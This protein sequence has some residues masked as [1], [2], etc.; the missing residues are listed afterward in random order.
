MSYVPL[1][2]ISSY[3]LLQSPIRISELITEA[4]ERGY[5]AL[6]LTDINVMYGSVAFY[7][8]CLKANIKP[9]IGLT[10]Q[11]PGVILNEKDYPIVLIAKDQ[12]GYANLMQLST[13]RR[14]NPDLTMADLSANLSHLFIIL[15]PLAE[16]NDLLL[17]GRQAEISALLHSI[18]Q[19][20]LDDHSLK[21][22]IDY[23]ASDSMID[24]LSKLAADNQ[25]ALIADSPVDYI[26]ATD[27]FPMQVLK[28]IGAGT[29]ISNVAQLSQQ[30]GPYWLRPAEQMDAE[31]QQIHLQAAVK[32]AE[33]LVDNCQVEIKKQQPKLPAFDTPNGIDSGQY[34]RQLCEKGLKFRLKRNQIT[35]S[36]PYIDRLNRELGVIHSMGFDNYFLIVWDVINFAHKTHIIT[37]PGRGSAAGSLVAYVLFITDVDPIKYN[38][39]FER[40][41]NPERV[42][43]PDIDL[44]IPDNKRDEVIQYV[45]RRYGHERVAQ[46]I[47]FGTLAA[48]QS[49]RDVGRVFGL[50]TTQQDQ[51]S[52]A[53]PAAF[54]VSLKDALNNSQKLKNLIADSP[55][56]Q[57]LF[58][59]AALLEGLPRHYSTH[60]AGLVLSDNPLVNLVPLQDGNDGLLMTQYSKNYVESVGLLKIDF[61]GLRNLSILA[62]ALNEVKQVTGTDLDISAIPL[63]D[64]KTIDLFARGDTTGIFQFESAGIRNV[65]RRLKPE[66]FE[67]VA[68][69]NALYRPGP[70][71]NIDEVVKRKNGHE[72]LTYPDDSLID[73]LKPTYGV[74]VYQEQ[75]MLVA[76]KLAGF[77]LGQADILRRAMSKKK[78]NVMEQMKSLFLSGAKKRGHPEAVAN[79]VFDYIEKFA[80]YGFNKSHAVAYSKMA[81]ELAYLKVYYPGEF[82]V[83][84]LNSVQGNPVKIKEYL[85]DAK[86]M[87]VG[88]S[89]PN[90]NQSLAA[91]SFQAGEIVFGLESIKGVRHDM[92]QDMLNDRQ[93]NGA[94][95]NFPDF[96]T[97]LPGKYRKPELI[98]ALIYSGALDTFSFNRSEL[99]AAAPEFISSVELSG[100]SMSLFKALEPKMPKKPEL[101]LM[102]KLAKENQYLGAYLSGHPTERFTELAN[103]LQAKATNQLSVG[104]N[105]IFIILYVTK[106]KVIRTKTGKQMAFVDGNDQVGE[107]S[108]TVFPNIFSQ[109][110]SWLHKDMVILVQ[111]KV[112]KTTDIQIVANRIEP[113]DNA[114]RRLGHSATQPQWYLRIDQDHDKNTI[115]HNLTQLATTA[116][117]SNSVVVYEAETK[118]TW[119]LDNQFDLQ[120]GDQVK[121]KL[122]TIFGQKNVVYK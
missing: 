4:K 13:L 85:L 67:D 100:N 118:R 19:L 121:N 50:N 108:V 120:S 55:L 40:F 10:L 44:D 91:F 35:D 89:A 114:M 48:K 12:V 72:G 61:L 28:A 116:H 30:V 82:H 117:G 84:L 42:Q 7:D 112:E 15:P 68:L 45:H 64:P 96:L 69:V 81:Y 70:M 102:E 21:I 113:A 33:A 1:Q 38:L 79:K 93:Q 43:M 90:I 5:K 22:G 27:Y 71:Q 92:V 36:Q 83:A 18:G 26:N 32:E 8:A 80:N 98:N 115:F 2:V 39:L 87:K 86:A 6:A 34:L 97:R 31:Y 103:E 119:K 76:S 75:V 65:L 29:K 74:I 23:H 53:I 47:T 122:I 17:Q 46:I 73:I 41:L 66:C 63:D 101:P 106:V 14:T 77:S 54:H 58:D 37:G 51:W 56:N 24:M 11:L 16:V 20:G 109:T 88:V 107:T 95:K 99:I 57:A 78:L 3:S 110:Q 104:M 60:A 94:F 111:G 59:T 52:K 49:I 9:I 62:D 25:V 105:N